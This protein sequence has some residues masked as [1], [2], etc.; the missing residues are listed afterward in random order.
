[1]EEHTFTF[2]GCHIFESKTVTYKPDSE[3]NEINVVA[4]KHKVISKIKAESNFGDSFFS[5]NIEGVKHKAGP[6]VYKNGYYVLELFL[7][8]HED[9][10]LVPQSETIFF[11]PPIISISGADDCTDFGVTFEAFQGKVFK[12]KQTIIIK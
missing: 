9:A 8:P 2:D 10:I 6:L 12:G 3:S 1:M 11:N 4:I 7:A 5:V